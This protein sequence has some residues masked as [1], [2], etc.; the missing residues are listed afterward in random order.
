M[1]ENEI[2]FSLFILTFSNTDT[3]L[4]ILFNAPVIN[5]NFCF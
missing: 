5:R 4:I 3:I 1:N 2:L